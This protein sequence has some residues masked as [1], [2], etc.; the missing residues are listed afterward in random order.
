MTATTGYEFSSD[1]TELALYV[2]V[3]VEIDDPASLLTGSDDVSY[4][5]REVFVQV[6]SGSAPYETFTELGTDSG[7]TYT[8]YES[9]VSRVGQSDSTGLDG[10]EFVDLYDSSSGNVLAVSGSAT[11]DQW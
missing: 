10:L 7:I 11:A 1:S 2:D 5:S 6:T 8:N 4:V 9:T 3:E